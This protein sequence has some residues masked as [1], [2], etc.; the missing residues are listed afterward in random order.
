M[1][2]EWQHSNKNDDDMEVE[3]KDKLSK[4]QKGTEYHLHPKVVRKKVILTP[5]RVA[6]RARFNAVVLTSVF[7]GTTDLTAGRN[8]Q[9]KSR[10]DFLERA[11]IVKTCLGRRKG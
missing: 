7:W 4:R 10:K 6:E 3:Q 9:Q 2:R 8:C 5:W 1:M 11:S